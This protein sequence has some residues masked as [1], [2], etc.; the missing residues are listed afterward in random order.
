MWAAWIVAAVA[1]LAAAF[2]LRVLVAFLSERPPSVF[3][4]VVPVRS[5]GHR[6][7]F[8][9]WSANYVE[10]DCQTAECDSREYYDE[11]LENG[12]YAKQ[13]CSSGLIVFN[14]RAVSDGL[15]WRSIPTKRGHVFREHRL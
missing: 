10:V 13:E 9:A 4:W 5:E 11:L 2:M 15:G 14:V 7:M 12:N 1:L 8:E 3:Y 6:G